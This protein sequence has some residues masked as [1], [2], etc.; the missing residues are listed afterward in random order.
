[1]DT[2]LRTDVDEMYEVA[3]RIE[4]L[5]NRKTAPIQRVAH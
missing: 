3:R 2:I 1:M 4:K 5:T